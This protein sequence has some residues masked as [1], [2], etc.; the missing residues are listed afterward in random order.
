MAKCPWP[1]S[2]AA[3]PDPATLE[4]EVGEVHLCEHCSLFYWV[5]STHPYVLRQERAASAAIIAAL[6]KHGK[7]SIRATFA[8]ILKRKDVQEALTARRVRD[9]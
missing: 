9:R 4:L 2:H 7:P 1:P 8:A 3:V 6:A 5:K